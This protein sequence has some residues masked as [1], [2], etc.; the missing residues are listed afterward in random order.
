MTRESPDISGD[1]VYLLNVP[2]RERECK[3]G[4]GNHHCVKT[5]SES[6]GTMES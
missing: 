6:G 1:I 2:D 5:A 3:E 4:R